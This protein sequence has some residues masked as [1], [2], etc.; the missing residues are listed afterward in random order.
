MTSSAPRQYISR[1]KI[2]SF[3]SCRN[4]HSSPHCGSRIMQATFT[5]KAP[6]TCTQA[7][8]H[9]VQARRCCC[10]QRACRGSRSSRVR[11]VPEEAAAGSPQLFSPQFAAVFQQA[12]E[13]QGEEALSGPAKVTNERYLLHHSFPF[14]T[15]LNPGGQQSLASLRMRRQPSAQE[16]VLQASMQDS[17]RNLIQLQRMKVHLH[18]QLVHN[19]SAKARVILLPH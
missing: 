19:H 10:Q 18:R 4:S 17:R 14:N 3:S 1:R 9:P 16:H 13:R 11:A 15:L 2:Q 6:V 5:G 8:V 12:L 7:T